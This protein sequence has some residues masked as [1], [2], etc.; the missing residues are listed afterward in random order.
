MPRLPKGKVLLQVYVS[1]DLAKKLKSVVKEKYESLRGGLSQ[2]VEQALRAWVEKAL[3]SEPSAL[4]E[5]RG[6]HTHNSR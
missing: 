2:E 5:E 3:P 4:K 6:A 1:E